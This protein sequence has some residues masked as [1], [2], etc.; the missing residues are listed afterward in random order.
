[1]P[2]TTF[3]FTPLFRTSV[4]FDRMSRL[5]DSAARIEEGA[6]SY[7][8]YNIEQVGEHKYSIMMALAGFSEQDLKLTVHESTLTVK[9][10]PRDAGGGKDRR[11]LHRGIAGRAF[12]RKFNLAEYVEV[13]G[14]KLENGLLQVDLEQIVP[15]EKRPRTIEIGGPRQIEGEAMAA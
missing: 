2:A 11:F 13:V 8:P 12:E 3:D 15:E 5:L 10:K 4:G 6:L 7:P 1:M 9:G 14:A